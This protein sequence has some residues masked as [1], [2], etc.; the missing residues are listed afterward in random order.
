VFTRLESGKHKL[1]VSDTG[2]TWWYTW[3]VC[4]WGRGDRTALLCRSQSASRVPEATLFRLQV[5]KNKKTEKSWGTNRSLTRRKWP[6]SVSFSKNYQSEDSIVS[7]Y[8]E[9]SGTVRPT[10][11]HIPRKLYLQ[12]HRWEHLQSRTWLVASW[13]PIMTLI[14]RQSQCLRQRSEFRAVECKEIVYVLHSDMNHRNRAVIQWQG[15]IVRRKGCLESCK[16]RQTGWTQPYR[17]ALLMRSSS[18]FV[19]TKLLWY[20][21][22]FVMLLCNE[23]MVTDHSR[24]NWYQLASFPICWSSEHIVLGSS[25]GPAQTTCSRI[26]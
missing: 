14:V 22:Y 6:W 19:T 21:C 4:S 25:L 7:G 23:V 5:N 11:R 15:K 1:H 20:S 13:R 26:H 24:N 16:N 17:N 2:S 3:V 12:Q 18:C 8:D 10:R 9:T